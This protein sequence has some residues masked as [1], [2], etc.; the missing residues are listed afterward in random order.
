VKPGGKSVPIFY[1]PGGVEE[2][3]YTLSFLCLTKEK[4]QK[5]VKRFSALAKNPPLS[6]K[7]SKVFVP[8][9]R[10]SSRNLFNPLLS[11][12]LHASHW[13]RLIIFNDLLNGV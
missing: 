5:K 12:F 3:F 10:D 9:R 6:V 4:K 8:I 11:D 1:N 2:V 13:M 7:L